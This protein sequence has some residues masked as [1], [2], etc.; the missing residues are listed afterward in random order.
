MPVLPSN[1]GLVSLIFDPPSHIET[2]SSQST[3]KFT[4]W[5]CYC[6]S[7]IF[8]KAGI[9]MVDIYLSE[10]SLVLNTPPWNW[11]NTVVSKNQGIFLLVL[12][13]LNS[14]NSL[15]PCNE[16]K[17]VFAKLVTGVVPT[18]LPCLPKH[19]R[20][21]PEASS[22]PLHKPCQAQTQHNFFVLSP[23]LLRSMCP[24]EHLVHTKA[25]A[26]S[27]VV[28]CFIWLAVPLQSSWVGPD[29]I[30]ARK[31]WL[32]HMFQDCVET[33]GRENWKHCKSDWNHVNCAGF[34]LGKYVIDSTCKHV[35]KVMWQACHREIREEK[36]YMCKKKLLDREEMS[37]NTLQT[38]AVVS[39]SDKVRQVSALS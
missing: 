18:A 15:Y 23:A 31:C 10:V 29:L 3:G 32:R 7:Y 6:L 9:T 26:G 17:G 19:T 2:V 35:S 13:S 28:I 30:H 27:T 20:H 24:K 16:L 4:L 39:P 33:A 22:P 34:R 1:R 38:R 21:K 8:T 37:G 25:R 12:S 5:W 11:D 36:N 14:Y